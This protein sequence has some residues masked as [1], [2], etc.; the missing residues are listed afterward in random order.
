MFNE[1]MASWENHARVT[2][3]ASDPVLGE[4]PKSGTPF[5]LQAL[6]T[7]Q[8]LSVHEYRKGKIATFFDRVW[9]KTIIPNL[10]KDLLKGKEFLANLDA[11]EL[12]EIAE[13]V[14][15]NQANKF[16]KERI[17]SGGLILPG[18][19]DEFK[20]KA[21]ESFRKGGN[22][23]FLKIIKDEFKDTP[24]AVKINIV[25][26]QAYLAQM[27]DK[28]SGVLQQIIAN[29]AILQNKVARKIFDKILEGS[30]L[31]PIEFAD[32]G[33]PQQLLQPVQGQ[34]QTQPLQI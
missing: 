20:E 5:R 7:A 28:L 17:L 6:V 3:S 34:P 19:V 22:K 25:G 23:R 18:E 9:S 21:K 26:K 24:L 32:I 14:V 27:T 15:T 16:V 8:G 33:Q 2:G 30:G 31:S 13:R 4:E 11:D 12:E 10:V 29:P 1:A